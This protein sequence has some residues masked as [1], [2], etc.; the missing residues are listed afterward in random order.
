MNSALHGINIFCCDSGDFCNRDVHPSYKP[1][2]PSGDSFS[3]SP[4]LLVFI[5]LP[6][7][8]AIIGLISYLV[9]RCN[10]ANNIDEPNAAKDIEICKTTNLNQLTEELT[11]GSGSGLTILVQRKINKEIE[12]TKLIG[13]GRYGKVYLAKFR[14]ENVAAKVFTPFAEASWKR[15]SEIY[16]S[17]VMRHENI[18]G[19]IA[20]DVDGI[21]QRMLIT[22]YHELGSLRD[23]LQL[24]SVNSY[25]LVGMA[26]SLAA[27]IAHLHTEIS[28][29]T[30]KSA[31]AHCDLTSKNILVKKDLCCAISDFGMAVKY[32][33]DQ[34]AIQLP[35]N[36]REATIRYM[37]PECLNGTIVA[38]KF[39][40]Y[41]MTD[42]YAVGLVFW[43]MARCC[44]TQV[45]DEVSKQTISDNY[46]IPYHDMVP[47]DPTVEEMRLVVCAENDQAEG[48][49]PP[50]SER[51][52]DDEVM[53]L[54]KGL[55]IDCWKEKPLARLTSLRVKKSLGKMYGKPDNEFLPNPVRNLSVRTV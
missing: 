35:S 31:I 45:G 24:Q 42:M 12:F 39:E 52:D 14:G 25:Q 48:S 20:S 54:L 30:G 5:I 41:K 51:W 11:S 13:Q 44:E 28:G 29:S 16:Q 32:L 18:M 53:H 8:L 33:S 47:D 2:V 34:D 3:P 50:F 55:I 1:R 21:G 4:M 26:H 27:G 19:F 49:R 9:R 7:I 6:P 43:E 38:D 37:A 17:V 10:A 46:S 23:F 36:T 22:H 40:S 15:E